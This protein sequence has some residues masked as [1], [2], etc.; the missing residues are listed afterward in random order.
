VF[1]DGSGGVNLHLK[2][3]NFEFTPENV[4][5]LNIAGQGHAHLYIDGKKITRIYGDWYHLPTSSMVNGEYTLSVD[6]NGNDHGTYI[7]Q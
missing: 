4:N 1:I 2:T 5:T 6:L 7:Y 3:Q